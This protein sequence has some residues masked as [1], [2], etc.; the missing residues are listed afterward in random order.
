MKIMLHRGYFNILM[1]IS[2]PGVFNENADPGPQHQLFSSSE[3]PIVILMW[4]I[5]S[6]PQWAFHSKPIQELGKLEEKI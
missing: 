4:T 5:L 6:S 1:K 2:D 3:M